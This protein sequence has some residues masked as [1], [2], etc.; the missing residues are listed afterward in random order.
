MRRPEPHVPIVQGALPLRQ[1]VDFF[2]DVYNAI[3]PIKRTII[4]S[5]TIDFASVGAGLTVTN[6][7][8]VTGARANNSIELGLPAI[9]ILGSGLLI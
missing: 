9:G 5:A 4:A 1:W 7:V 3:S 6:T 2:F 8:T